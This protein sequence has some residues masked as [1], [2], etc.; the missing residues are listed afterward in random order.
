MGLID[1]LRS[2]YELYRLEQRYTRR[3]KRTTFASGATYVDGEYVYRNGRPPLSPGE[4]A[5]NDDDLPSPSAAANT[6]APKSPA[7]STGPSSPSTPDVG[8][9]KGPWGRVRDD[10]WGAR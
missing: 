3:D 8:E 9:V 5:P 1:T 2:K 4:G 6:T 7:S 10:V